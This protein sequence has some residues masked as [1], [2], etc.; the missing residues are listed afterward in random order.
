MAMLASTVEDRL[1]LP[2]ELLDPFQKIKY[3][4]KDFDPEYLQEI[5]PLMTVALGLATRRHGDKW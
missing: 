2:V 1:G 3:N 4:D 5:G